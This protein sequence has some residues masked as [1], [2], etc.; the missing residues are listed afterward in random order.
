MST[1]AEMAQQHTEDAGIAG[2][3]AEAD[4]LVIIRGR[5]DWA[6]RFRPGE[7]LDDLPE[8]AD[9]SRTWSQYGD[10]SGS[11]HIWSRHWNPLAPTACFYVTEVAVP[12]GIDVWVTLE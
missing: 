3:P 5:D 6:R 8:G 12:E 4:G 1:T 2:L 11:G 7:A 9:Q 10:G